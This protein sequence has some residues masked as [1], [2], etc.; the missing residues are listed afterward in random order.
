NGLGS[1][2]VVLGV[3]EQH[4]KSAVPRCCLKAAD[5]FGEVGISNFRDHKPEYI[6]APSRKT[7]GVHVLEVVKLTN[8]VQHSA[9]GFVGNI[10]RVVENARNG[11]RRNSSSLGDFSHGM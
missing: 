1:F 11:R 4:V 3:A 5:D 6:A 9:A 2:P 10:F 8:H 7:L